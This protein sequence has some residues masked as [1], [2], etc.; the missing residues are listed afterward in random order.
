M[1]SSEG[2]LTFADLLAGC[3]RSA[4]HLE[5]RDRYDDNPRIEAWRQGSRF[6]W[7]D[8]KSW[9]T[10]YHQAIEDAVSRGVI[11]RRVRIVSEPVSEYIRWEHY[12]TTAIVLAGERVRWMPRRRTTDIALPGN[13]FWLFDGSLLRVHHFDGDGNVVEDELTTDPRS[14]ALCASAFD[15]VWERAVAHDQY[16]V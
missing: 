7:R 3:T 6:D 4:V 14:I 1:S 2:T 10:D 15:S 8:R 5:L 13:D 9:W 16:H 12:T 11:V